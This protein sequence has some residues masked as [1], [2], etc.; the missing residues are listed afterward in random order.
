MFCR[1]VSDDV[2]ELINMSGPDHTHHVRILSRIGYYPCGPEVVL[3]HKEP[4][5][6]VRGRELQ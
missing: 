1:R 3:H 5:L 4:R 6:G 2:A